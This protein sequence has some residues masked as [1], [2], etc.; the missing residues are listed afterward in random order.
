MTGCSGFS[1][2]LVTGLLKVFVLVLIAIVI[3]RVLVVI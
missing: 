3:F 1:R 2:W